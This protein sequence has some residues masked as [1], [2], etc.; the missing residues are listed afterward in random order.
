VLGGLVVVVLELGEHLVHPQSDSSNGG[1]QWPVRILILRVSCD[2][3]R[4][5]RADRLPF[6][7]L[8]E[9]R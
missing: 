1:Q 2:A 4:T 5:W 7:H 6:V 8:P 9:L 3:R